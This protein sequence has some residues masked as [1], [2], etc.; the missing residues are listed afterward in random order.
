V[1]QSRGGRTYF[2][3]SIRHDG[4][5]TKRYLGAGPAAEFAARLLADARLARE[6]DAVALRDRAQAFAPI[7]QALDELDAPC[8]LLTEAALGAA[9]YARRHY[10][11]KRIHGRDERPTP[12]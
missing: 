12:V 5:V 1:W 9:G 4:R 8:R 10:E 3:Q 7:D 2:Y 6:A 11:W